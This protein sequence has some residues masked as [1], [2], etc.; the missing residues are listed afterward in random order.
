MCLPSLVI[1]R[2]NEAIFA[3]GIINEVTGENARGWYPP[4]GYRGFFLLLKTFI[5]GQFFIVMFYWHVHTNDQIQTNMNFKV[6]IFF[7]YLL[8]KIR[9]CST[10]DQK[11]K[12]PMLDISSPVPINQAVLLTPYIFSS[13]ELRPMAIVLSFSSFLL[14]HVCG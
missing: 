7:S 2:Y 8:L 5:D 1:N 4:P 3:I 13:L 9:T 14:L 6:I 10:E 11:G 12:V